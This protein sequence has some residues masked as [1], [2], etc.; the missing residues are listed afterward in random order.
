MKPSQVCRTNWK[1]PH[2]LEQLQYVLIDVLDLVCRGGCLL[3]DCHVAAALA[4]SLQAG[5]G[6]HTGERPRRR[7]GAELRQ[8]A[9]STHWLPWGRCSS[10]QAG[11]L[12]GASRLPALGQVLSSSGGR[13]G[14]NAILGSMSGCSRWS[15]LWALRRASL[16][17]AWLCTCSCSRA[18]RLGGLQLQAGQSELAL[19]ASTQLLRS[20]SQQALKAGSRRLQVLRHMSC[21]EVALCQSP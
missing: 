18:Q 21:S 16:W 19:L 14:C 12:E 3:L 15:H 8:L 9:C 2:P 7:T 20:H 10:E 17:R 4:G 13:V 6:Q 1:R 5:A 11:G